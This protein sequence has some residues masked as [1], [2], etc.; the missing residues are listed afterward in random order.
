[1]PSFFHDQAYFLGRRTL[2]MY[3]TENS[4][5]IFPEIKLRGLVPDFYIHV[6][7]SDLYSPT[8]GQQ[9]QYGK[10]GGPTVARIY[11]LLTDRT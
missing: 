8:I 7:V 6:T 3:R 2:E 4:K 9:T 5:P 1:M 11:K 10:I